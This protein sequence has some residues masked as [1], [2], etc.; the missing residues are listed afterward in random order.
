MNEITFSII[1]ETEN[2]ETSDIDRLQK[3]IVSL[4][5]QSPEQANEVV[6]IDSGNTP[7]QVLNQLQLRYPWL[8]IKSA[9]PETEY[10]ESKMLGLEWTTGEIIV[11]YDSDCIYEG[12]WLA[13]LVGSFDNVNIQIVCGET[14]T[15]GIGLYGTAIALCYVFPQYSGQSDLFPVNQY[16]LNN[17]AFRRSV[18]QTIPI[19]TDLPLYRGNCVIHAQTL[20]NAGYTIWRQP[21]ARSLH[22]LPN[23]L[24]NYFKRFL[25]IGHDLYWQKQL[26][27]SPLAS[28]G[29][30][31]IREEL[32]DD[33]DEF[34]DDPTITE[35][36]S[37]LAIGLDRITKM[38]QRDRRHAFYL[39]FC[40]PIVLVSVLLIAIGY[41]ITCRHPHQ[42]RDRLT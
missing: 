24:G 36:R 17:V 42:L 40:L 2:I 13:T 7:R 4:A 30:G 8:T 33:S 28:L 21:K 34:S 19:P 23:G 14:T 26:V 31:G 12:D 15:D 10:Y 39:P 27:G 6:L 35:Q 37:N 18:L 22:A 38:I 1:L 9:P 32:I 29:K 20:L 16:F 11:Y 5:A 3:S 41:Q 25:L